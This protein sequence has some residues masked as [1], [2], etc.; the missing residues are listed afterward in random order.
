MLHQGAVI[1]WVAFCGI[2]LGYVPI[3]AATRRPWVV[4]VVSFAA[5]FVWALALGQGRFDFRKAA[6]HLLSTA[7]L[8]ALV[9]DEYPQADGGGER[10]VEAVALL[11]LFAYCGV[12]F[13]RH[14]T[15]FPPGRPAQTGAGMDTR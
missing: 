7:G 2:G 10:I 6:Y 3:A 14:G 8:T 15:L 13:V 9:L 1:G 5:F 12:F 11:A 4:A